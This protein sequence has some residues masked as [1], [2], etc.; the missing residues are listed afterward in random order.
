[1]VRTFPR[2]LVKLRKTLRVSILT[3]YLTPAVCGLLDH[4]RHLGHE[5]IRRGG[6]VQLLGLYGEEGEIDTQVLPEKRIAMWGVER[7]SLNAAIAEAELDWLIV[8]LSSYGYSRWGAPW[9]LGRILYKLK[10]GNRVRLAA[11]VHETHCMPAQLGW[12]GPILSLWQRYTVSSLLHCC[13]MIFPTVDIWLE[14]CLCDYRL[15]KDRVCLLPIA[16]NVQSVIL[17]S[18]ERESLREALGILPNSKVAAIFGR[19]DSQKL[20]LRRLSTEVRR[21][22]LERKIEHIISIGGDGPNPPKDLWSELG[23]KEFNGRLHILGP[24]PVNM[25]GKYLSICDIG[26]VSAPLRMWKKSGAARAYEQAYLE[27][28]IADDSNNRMEIVHPDGSFPTWEETAEI[29]WKKL[30]I[31]L[32]GGMSPLP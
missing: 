16:A 13:D 9:G 11:I 12:K 8:Q 4:S 32:P 23:G 28:W 29:L 31:G 15:P 1:M 2:P 19:W 30:A 24:Q 22:L 18:S 3:P 7:G 21:A 14:Q 6:T 20:A 17:T 25:V 27:L 26:L 5:L 10:Q